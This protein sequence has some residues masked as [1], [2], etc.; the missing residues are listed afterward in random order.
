M[1]GN[2]NLHKDYITLAS[3]KCFTKRQLFGALVF[4]PRIKCFCETFVLQKHWGFMHHCASHP[5]EMRA[6]PCVTWLF[7]GKILELTEPLSLCIF[8][9]KC[10]KDLRNGRK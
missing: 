1:F 3:S 10:L 2:K 8:I 5:S 6:K 4:K 7:V 9:F